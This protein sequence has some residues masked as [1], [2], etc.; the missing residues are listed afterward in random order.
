MRS[1]SNL[2]G[3]ILFMIVAFIIFPCYGPGDA[4]AAS[5]P[6][7]GGTIREGTDADLA[8]TDPH[9]GSLPLN[10]VMMNHIFET[11]V[12]FGEKM[13]FVPVLAERWDI[14]PDYKTYTFYLRKGKL[15]HNG[16]EMVADDVKY[17]IERIMDPK[18]RCPRRMEFVNAI[19]S[20]EV[21]DKYTVV[22]HM[23]KENAELLYLLAYIW[24]VMGIVAREEVEK[25]G[26][27][28]KHPVGTGPYKFVE[29][30]QAQY[31]LVERFDQYKPQPGPQNGF[32]GERIA[33]ADKIQWVV[34]PEESGRIMA[35]LNKEI[36]VLRDFP[37]SYLE[38]FHQDYAKRGLVIHTTPGLALLS[39]SFSFNKPITNNLK[40]RQACAY[41]IDLEAVSRVVG[42]GPGKS[43]SSWVVPGSPYWTP[44]HNTWYKK[45]V[46]KA[47]QLLKEAGYKGEEVVISTSKTP[48]DYY[49]T[50]VVLQAELAAVGVNVKLDVV[51]LP[52]IAKRFYDK[53]FQM[54]T[55][56]GMH[57]D[58][59]NNYAY[60]Q[61][62]GLD[63]Q[64][65]RMKQIR[66]E[67]SKTLDVN[68]RKKLFEEAHKLQYEHVPAI[69]INLRPVY[70]THWDYVK[71]FRGV[72]F[73]ERL[74]G[75]W[76]DK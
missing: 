34:I 32:G 43:Y 4:S 49:R 25:E 61:Y 72:T 2:Q 31:V 70:D 71:G 3:A 23:K 59:A 24:P 48:M 6:K 22:F 73:L 14:S 63:D 39:V 18:T 64:V 42:L 57:A 65:P 67:A 1:K 17:S 45:D 38:K 30:K 56:I 10:G 69:V 44:Y 51:E 21:K 74:W 28:I 9:V 16:R 7:W 58:P 54:I 15:F 66:E 11:L 60:N 62:T 13:E 50:A 41:T 75:V 55:W 12:G 53:D 36:D 19:E 46:N 40:F 47:K 5:G 35:L 26:G 33:Y 52:V 29:W 76:L 20:I 37:A 27:V 68:L 8:S